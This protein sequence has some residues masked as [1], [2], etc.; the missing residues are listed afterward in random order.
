MYIATTVI[1]LG[2]LA[3]CSFS[4]LIQLLSDAKNPLFSSDSIRCIETDC[5]TPTFTNRT[6][7]VEPLN[8][9]LHPRLPAFPAML[10]NN[11]YSPSCVLYSCY[12]WHIIID[13][14]F[15]VICWLSKKHWGATLHPSGRPPACFSS[16]VSVMS[17]SKP[18]MPSVITRYK[19]AHNQTHTRAHT[20]SRVCT[21]MHTLLAAAEATARRSTDSNAWKSAAEAAASC[22]NVLRRSTKWP[23]TG[24][25]SWEAS[26]QCPVGL[27]K[28]FGGEGGDISI[29][30][31]AAQIERRQRF[32]FEWNT[33]KRGPGAVK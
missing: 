32:Q 7:A 31:P 27:L 11:A 20:H 13:P 17:L 8:K 9:L 1:I 29:I 28:P 18:T 24:R 30:R 14:H 2:Y 25:R 5:T 33:W 15:C 22:V 12:I 10:F 3:C 6:L 21:S 16:L 19:H 26:L 23:A 4:S